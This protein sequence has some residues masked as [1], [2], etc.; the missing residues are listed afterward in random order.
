MVAEHAYTQVLESRTR[1]ILLTF[2][3]IPNLLICTIAYP[4]TTELN[5]RCD[6]INCVCL[7]ENL[8]MDSFE[9]FTMQSHSSL[10]DGVSESNVSINTTHRQFVEDEISGSL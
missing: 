4:A 6:V 2:S 1:G 9:L 10:E 3:K 8:K 7:L 5:I